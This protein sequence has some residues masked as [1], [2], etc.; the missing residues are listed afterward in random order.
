[1]AKLNNSQRVPVSGYRNKLI[2]FDWA[3][4]NIL[5]N[6]SNFGILEGFLSEL[7]KENIKIN[8]L[9]ESEGNQE[10]KTDK[11]NRVDLLVENSKDELIIIEIQN[12]TE[13][14]YLHR[15]VYGSSKVISENLNLG[16]PYSKIKKVISVSIVYFD[17]GHGKDYVYKGITTFEGIHKKDKLEL[18][19][20]QKKLF[21]DIKIEQIFPE[22]YLL[23]VKKFDNKTRDTLDEWIYFLKNE[24]IKDNFKAKGLKEAKEKLDILKLPKKEQ[25]KYQKYLENLSYQASMAQTL[26]FE[27]EQER[28]KMRKELEQEANKKLFKTA[29]KLKDKGMPIVEVSEIT[30]L[31]I[32]EIENL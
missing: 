5:R 30:G 26:N 25:Q 1:M 11:F 10:T 22:Y 8:K 6:K 32:E 28:E 21:G 2:R 3:I 31:S 13:L 15:L 24:E 9:L 12:T 14:D 20:E 18:S 16:E 4:K 27:L 29:K 17:L 23:K 19:D 7:L